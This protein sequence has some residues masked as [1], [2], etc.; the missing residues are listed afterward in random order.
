METWHERELLELCGF[1]VD[2]VAF[3]QRQ[4]Q[5]GIDRAALDSLS[6]LL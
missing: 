2:L 5:N 4:G 3:Q 6:D 1:V